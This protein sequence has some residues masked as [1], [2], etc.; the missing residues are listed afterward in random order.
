MADRISVRRDGLRIYDIVLEHSFRGLKAEL[1]KL[2]IEDRKICIVTDSNVA[3]LYLDEVK[4]ILS[5]CCKSVSV[6]VFPAGEENKNLETVRKLYEHLIAENF[7]R[8]DMLAALGGGVVGDLC[9]FGAATYLRGIDFIQIPTTLLAQVDSSIGGKTGGDFDAY[10]NMIGAFHMPRLVYTN[11]GVLRTLSEE[12]FSSGMGEVIK[13]GLI[14]DKEY[15]QWLKDNRKAILNRD[16]EFCQ[17]VVYVSNM[18]KKQVVEQD[19][20]EQGERA[21]LNFG[22]TLGHAIEKLKNFELLHGECVAIGMVAASYLSYLRNMI[23]EAQY[24][25]I[26]EMIQQMQLPTTVEGLTKEDIIRVSK[27]D[28]KMNA[29]QIR[30]ILLDDLGNAVMTDDVT[31]EELSQALDAVI[32]A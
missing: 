11:L 26:C 5:S 32:T 10:K 12:Q 22:H 15:Y 7:D 30:F 18:I 19:P 9:G 20:K 1:K 24:R 16:L 27:N 25:T 31:D 13:H 17:R 28:K 8:K 3:G 23:T 21:L 2:A 4:E 29:G 14:K 6:F